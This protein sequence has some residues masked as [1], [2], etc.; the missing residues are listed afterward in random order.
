[1]LERTNHLILVRQ[2]QRVEG[3][4]LLEAMGE[5][6]DPM[7][8]VVVALVVVVQMVVRLVHRLEMVV[9]GM[10]VVEMAVVGITV[11]ELRSIFQGKI[12]IC[13]CWGI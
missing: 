2:D 11:A 8:V 13:K 9:V 6:E 12:L 1:M 3:L 7:E 10:A 5:A 4:F